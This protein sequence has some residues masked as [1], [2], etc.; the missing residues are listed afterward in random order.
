MDANRSL[1]FQVKRGNCGLGKGK[2]R[3]LEELEK[4]AGLAPISPEVRDDWMS[5]TP[6]TLNMAER[7]QSF[8]VEAEDERR[9]AAM[10]RRM[11]EEAERH[12]QQLEQM[13]REIQAGLKKI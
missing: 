1:F 10:Y 3:R 9:E 4:E 5:R 7:A 6:D 8:F 2:L 11:A 13:A 12:A